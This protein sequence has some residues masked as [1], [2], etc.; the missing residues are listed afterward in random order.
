MKKKASKTKKTASRTTATKARSY[1]V[2][3]QMFSPAM[4]KFGHLTVYSTSGD[5]SPAFV[6]AHLRQQFPG[7]APLILNW[8]E[9][10]EAEAAKWNKYDLDMASGPLPASA[11]ADGPTAEIAQRFAA[12]RDS[13]AQESTAKGKKKGG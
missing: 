6:H 2:T 9:I 11:R 12:A 7:F 4:Q 5:F 8:G 3:Y 10:S 13:M 1:F